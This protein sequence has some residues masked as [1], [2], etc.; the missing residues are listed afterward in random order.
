MA[1]DYCKVYL[2][3]VLLAAVLNVNIDDG[4][5]NEID[6]FRGGVCN[7]DYLQNKSDGT[8]N[9]VP[10][11]GDRVEVYFYVNGGTENF[12]FRGKIADI[13]YYYNVTQINTYRITVTDAISDLGQAELSQQIM[14]GGNTSGTV[15]AALMIGAGQ[16]T[17]YANI[18][19]GL[20]IISGYTYSGNC[21]D[22]INKVTTT[23]QGYMTANQNGSIDWFQR[24]TAYAAPTYSFSFTEALTQFR[25]DQVDVASAVSNRFNYV[26]V[27]PDGLANV[28]SSAVVSGAKKS[29]AV[30]TLDQTTTQAQYLAD[31]LWGKYSN[32][33]ADVQSVSTTIEAQNITAN[34]VSLSTLSVNTVVG[35]GFTPTTGG[36]GV[37]IGRSISG[38]PSGTRFTYYLSGVSL[39]PFLQLDNTIQGKLDYGRLSF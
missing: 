24:N 38:T 23:E 16:S 12:L 10:Q 19:T 35:V 22:Q 29:F 28:T 13:D 20:S 36:Y 1:G 14:T 31:Y 39:T 6:Q 34:K 7:F 2:N 37:I 33:D 30:S 3:T 32:T 18:Q 9:T 5:R 25:Y 27:Q 4:R 21:L 17:Y 8:A 11:I 26:V 15:V